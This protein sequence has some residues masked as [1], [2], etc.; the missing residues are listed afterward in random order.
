RLENGEQNIV[1]LSAGTA[2]DLSV[3]ENDS[4]RIG[5]IDVHVAGILDANAFDQN[6][7]ALSG[8]QITPLRY[9]TGAVDAGG[10]RLED[11]AAESLDLEGGASSAEAGSAYEHLSANQI[12]IVPASLCRMLLNS[13]LRA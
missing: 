8:E 9:S 3:R 5:G 4:I 6:V 13:P 11:T 12:V 10:R 7:V 2:S 1:Y